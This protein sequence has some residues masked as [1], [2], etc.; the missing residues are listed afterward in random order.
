MN[1]GII[2]LGLDPTLSGA[3]NAKKEEIKKDT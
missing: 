2:G 1:E 3:K